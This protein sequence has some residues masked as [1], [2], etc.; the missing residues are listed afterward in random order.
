MCDY[1]QGELVIC[2]QP[3]DRAA[4]SLIED[5]TEGALAKDGIRITETVEEKLKALG[6]KQRDGIHSKFARIIVPVG[7]EVFHINSLHARYTSHVAKLAA[8][9]E[10]QPSNDPRRR[11]LVSPNHYL[12]LRFKFEQPR[13]DNY[14]K[15][16]GW[17]AASTT[18]SVVAILDTGLDN[19][20]RFNVQAECDFTVS[21]TS[22]TAK[23]DHPL[24]H[25]TAIAE[26]IADFCPNAHL[27]IYKVADSTGRASELDTIAALV[28]DSGADIINMS[29]GFGLGDTICPRCGR[30]SHSSRAA[31][32][33]NA[34]NQVCD[35]GAIVLAAAG[36][37]S[38]SEL[39][40]PAR[41]ASA[42][43][44]ASVTEKYAL[45][46][47][48]NNGTT[49]E[50]GQAHERVYASPGGEC[51]KGAAPSEWIGESTTTD[52]LWGTS[53]ATAYA[54]AVVAH[55]WGTVVQSPTATSV[56]AHLKS[57][58]ETRAKYGH[59]LIQAT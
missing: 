46:S 47:F 41:F 16:L 27:V 20:A 40:Y 50:E 49:D 36:N 14:K 59:G 15:M 19:T 9:G 13:H 26:V 2:W 51:I 38:L 24:E 10:W 56:L 37:D 31:V 45:S 48:T 6:L 21:G 18:T 55:V 8:R 12:S 17:T 25:G 39:D 29:L 34:L 32:F 22:S 4:D 52:K 7:Q 33:E 30:E 58:V 42:L 35:A 28:A 11:L 5:L 43:A 3:E 53:F 57:H 44:I 23:D 54:S 1:L